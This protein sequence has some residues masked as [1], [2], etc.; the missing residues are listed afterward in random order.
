MSLFRDIYLKNKRIINLTKYGLNENIK[1]P[2][3]KVKM[4][5]ELLEKIEEKEEANKK[6]EYINKLKNCINKIFLSTQENN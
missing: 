4:Y 1:L 6:N 5:K 2:E 3:K